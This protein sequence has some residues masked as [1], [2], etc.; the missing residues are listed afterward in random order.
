MQ[1]LAITILSGKGSY[2]QTSVWRDWLRP[3]PIVWLDLE[4]GLQSLK[5]KRTTNKIRQTTQQTSNLEVQ[6]C[7]PHFHSFPRQKLSTHQHWSDWELQVSWAV[8]QGMFVQSWWISSH[9]CSNLKTH[10][11]VQTNSPSPVLPQYFPVVVSV[12]P[13]ASFLSPSSQCS[14]H[15]N[16]H[17]RVIDS[18]VD[19]HPKQSHLTT[20][21]P[22][23]P[24]TLP[25]QKE[26]D[27]SS[28]SLLHQAHCIPSVLSHLT[29][30]PILST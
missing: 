5:L 21:L 27:L 2:L 7:F 25:R 28:P 9:L 29:G 30:T 6:A 4:I 3:L 15:S 23:R 16:P 24:F 1:N 12:Y 17:H 8:D 10:H 19:V 20:L 14:C 22:E 18:V 26:G 11:F 13:V